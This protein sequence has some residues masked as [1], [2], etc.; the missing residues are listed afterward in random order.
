V[1]DVTKL[2]PNSVSITA[3]KKLFEMVSRATCILNGECKNEKELSQEQIELRVELGKI[4]LPILFKRCK[5]IFTQFIKD[6]KR[7]GK[8]PLA[9]YRRE[10]IES[11]LCE[12]KNT[13]VHSQLY[14]KLN[15]ITVHANSV[16]SG[17]AINGEYGLIVR[18]FPI[19]C[20]FIPYSADREEKPMKDNLMDMFKI[21]NIEL[22]L[23]NMHETN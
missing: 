16:S 21:V 8:C 3:L 17:H 6:D 4:A 7:S 19:L 10:E 12:L 13:K 23:N 22:G 18:L 20:E 9:K 1:E 14:E 5:L 15:E 11:A 2:R